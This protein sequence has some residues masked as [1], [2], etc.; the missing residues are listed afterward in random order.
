MERKRGAQLN[1]QWDHTCGVI[2]VLLLISIPVADRLYGPCDENGQCQRVHHSFCDTQSDAEQGGFCQCRNGFH[3]VN[4]VWI[5]QYEFQN[6]LLK[7]SLFYLYLQTCYVTVDLG[8]ICER[9]ENCEK[10]AGAVCTG[11]CVCDDD[12]PEVD[13]YCLSALLK[14]QNDGERVNYS[15]MIVLSNLLFLLSIYSTSSFTLIAA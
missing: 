14:G 15:K 13:G 11:R 3:N 9:N 7:I 2:A 12:Y 1:C 4:H 6:I 5:L 8:G 10:L